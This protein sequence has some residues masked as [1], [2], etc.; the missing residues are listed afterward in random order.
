VVVRCLYLLVN[1]A[2]AGTY[3]PANKSPINRAPRFKQVAGRSR[4]GAWACDRILKSRG[5]E[6]GSRTFFRSIQIQVSSNH[7]RPPLVLADGIR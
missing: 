4:R 2:E 1:P 7:E 6:C 3:R 5:G